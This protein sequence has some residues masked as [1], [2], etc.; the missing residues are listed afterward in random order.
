M[1]S[2]RATHN[3]IAVSANSAETAINTEQTLDTSMLAALTDVINMEPRREN[4]AEELNGLEEPDTVYDMGALS[5]CTLNFPKAQPQHFAFLSAFG[6]GSVATVAAGSGYL[7]TITPLENDLDENRSNPT[8][9]AAQRY[10]K[11]VLKRRYA[12]MTVDSITARFQRDAWCNLSGV[13]KGTGKVSDNMVEESITALDNTTSLTLAANAV[14]GSTAE[15]RLDNVQRIRVELTSGEWT[16]VDYSAVSADTPATITITDPGGAGASVNY[17]ILYAPIESGWMVFPA[18][19]S[20]TPL[21]VSQLTC[22]LGG[23]WDGS[24][25]VGGRTLSSE[26]ESIEWNLQNNMEVIFSIGAGGAYGDRAFR[27]GRVQTL[28]VNRDF[29]D[30]ILQQHIDDND[31]FGIYLLA[32]GA[33]Y[34]SPHA[35]QVEIIF[36]KCGVLSAPLS[37]NGKRLAEAGDLTVL[38]HDTYGSVIVNVKN[39]QANYAA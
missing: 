15:E 26:L 34:D 39:L 35:Y 19:V 14:E 38:E 29:R 27:D 36:P 12:S 10:G 6:L 18:R 17:K 32:Q 3:L 5:G 7:H 30:N 25:F 13:C 21:R 20:E 16:E 4:N 28:S 8:F 2:Y 1:R 37:V 31:T 24:A 11:T 33:V 22:K 23:A 9:T